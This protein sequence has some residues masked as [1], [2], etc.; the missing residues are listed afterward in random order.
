MDAG[1]SNSQKRKA[2][3]RQTKRKRKAMATDRS[4]QEQE[5][6]SPVETELAA[7]P[8]GA[9]DVEEDS[10]SAVLRTMDAGGSNPRKRKGTRR[11]SKRKRKAT[12][13][14]HSEAEQQQG[15]SVQTEITAVPPSAMS[16]EQGLPTAQVQPATGLLPSAP[17]EDTNN[18][19]S[20]QVGTLVDGG[21][22][23]NAQGVHIKGSTTLISARNYTN[24]YNTVFQPDI[25]KKDLEV[26]NVILPQ[27]N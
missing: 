19:T 16:I 22:L 13:T 27:Y 18:R 25:S 5:E 20:S 14:D 2:N 26:Y 3:R 11:Q 15:S 9:I 24:V 7:P 10:T 1:A 23:N 12:G 17:K 8:T 6:G 4:E 21:I